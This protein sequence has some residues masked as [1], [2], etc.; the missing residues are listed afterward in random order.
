MERAGQSPAD[1]AGGDAVVML[2]LGRAQKLDA[3]AVRR[4]AGRRQTQGNRFGRHGTESAVVAVKR[5]FR[6]ISRGKTD[7]APEFGLAAARSQAFVGESGEGLNEAGERFGVLRKDV[8]VEVESLAGRHGSAVKVAGP[9]DERAGGI[10]ETAGSDAGVFGREDTAIGAGVAP[11]AYTG[12]VAG[13]R[14]G[15]PAEEHAERAAKHVGGVT[16]RQEDRLAGHEFKAERIKIK[17]H[18][19]GHYTIPGLPEHFYTDR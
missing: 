10:G 3:K 14:A 5:R 19:S 2:E 12:V 9:E 15:D 6:E 1:G 18:V 13:G 11:R 16:G 4:R 17:P 8:Q 7:H